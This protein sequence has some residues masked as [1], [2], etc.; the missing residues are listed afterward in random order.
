[1][2]QSVTDIQKGKDDA[3]AGLM[4]HE[5]DALRVAE[6][7][8]ED[9]RGK[10]VTSASLWNTPLNAIASEYVV[11]VKEIYAMYVAG[12]T[13]GVTEKLY[14]PDGLIC[15]GI[16]MLVVLLLVALLRI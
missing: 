2:A 9:M 6:R 7:V 3:Y 13:D 4:K 12:N 5:I 11:F 8:S 1:M 16:T 10:K 15:G 14:T